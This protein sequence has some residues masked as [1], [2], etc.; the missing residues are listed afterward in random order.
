[1]VKRIAA[2]T[3]GLDLVEVRPLESPIIHIGYIDFKYDNIEYFKYRFNILYKKEN[4]FK[5]KK[6]KLKRK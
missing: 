3:I 6:F 2:H 4:R 5:F 1:M